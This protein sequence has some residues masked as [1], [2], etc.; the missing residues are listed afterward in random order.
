MTIVLMGF[1][2]FPPVMLSSLRDHLVRRLTI[3]AGAEIVT[4]F[5]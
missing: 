2:Q 5:E 4:L 1:G 3:R